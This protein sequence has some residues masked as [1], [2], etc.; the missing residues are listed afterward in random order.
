MVRQVVFIMVD[1]QSKF[2]LNC[3]DEKYGYLLKNLAE[4]AQNSTRFTSAYCVTPL[5]GPSRSAF[6]QVDILLI[7]A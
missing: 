2:M 4:L 3:Y 5:C 1:T 7:M 6:L